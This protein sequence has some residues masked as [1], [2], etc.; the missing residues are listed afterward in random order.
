[1]S[2]FVFNARF[3][4]KD[5][6]RRLDPRFAPRLF[7][8][9]F[10][11]AE[12]A[13]QPSLGVGPDGTPFRPEAFAAVKRQAAAYEKADPENKS[14]WDDDGM[15]RRKEMQIR[16]RALRKATME[17]VEASPANRGYVAFCSW[18]VEHDGSHVIMILQLQKDVFNAYHTLR[19]GTYREHEYRLERSLIEA[20]AF[21][22]LEANEKSCGR[23][24][25]ARTGTT[26]RTKAT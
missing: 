4:A 23:R 6:F 13:G 9:G 16:F 18:P 1:M 11:I 14:F 20:V 24:T 26:S 25:R 21:Q 12:K 5:I 3:E 15:Q 17:A 22:Y 10:R 19:K 7:F 8:V 2:G